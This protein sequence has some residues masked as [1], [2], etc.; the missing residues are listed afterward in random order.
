VEWRWEEGSP[1]EEGSGDGRRCCVG[2][3]CGV[4]NGSAVTG[5]A[6]LQIGDGRSISWGWAA[7]VPDDERSGV[8]KRIWAG[9]GWGKGSRVGRRNRFGAVGVRGKGTGAAGNRS[10]APAQPWGRWLARVW[11]SLFYTQGTQ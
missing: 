6:R 3:R 11:N 10:Q 4:G 2:M 8:G 7:P 9:A 1:S 5:G